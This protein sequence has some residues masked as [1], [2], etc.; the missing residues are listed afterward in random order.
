MAELVKIMVAADI[1]ALEMQAR[2][3][4]TGRTCRAGFRPRSEPSHSTSAI[5]LMCE[6]ALVR[7][8]T[9]ST[10][11]ILACHPR[12]LRR[13][14]STICGACRPVSWEPSEFRHGSRQA[15]RR[16]PPVPRWGSP[17]RSPRCWVVRRRSASGC[18]AVYL[19]G[20]YRRTGFRASCGTLCAPGFTCIVHRRTRMGVMSTALRLTISNFCAPS[21][22]WVSPGSIRND[23]REPR[24][25]QAFSGGRR[26]LP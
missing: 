25:V 19:V 20:N 22:T 2:P 16:I 26:S 17:H 23:C 21:R 5:V 18:I 9:P 6:K 7:R 10:S 1:L 15:S 11:E 4:S 12:W 13:C 24:R 8:P 3:G 14:T